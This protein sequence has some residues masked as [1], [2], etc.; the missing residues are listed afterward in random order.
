M[1]ETADKSEILKTDLTAVNECQIAELKKAGSE[2]DPDKDGTVFAGHVRNVQAAVIHTY[3]L[4]ATA[5]I[6]QA[7]P[8][9][10]ATLWK[11]MASFCEGALVVLKDLKGRYYQC[12]VTDLYD[13]VLDYREQAQKRYYQNLQDSECQTIPPGLFAETT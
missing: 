7:D 12:G 8:R 9:I 1:I 10:A 2:L 3:Q 6:R 11:D 13:L 4:T 5:S